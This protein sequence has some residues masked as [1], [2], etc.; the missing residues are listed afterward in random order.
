VPDTPLSPDGMYYWDGT[1]W[2]STLSHDGRSRWNGSAWIPV[3]SPAV[4]PIGYNAPA[5]TTREATSWTRPLQYAVAAWYTLA[6]ILAVSIPFWMS[7]P[8]TQ[9]INRSIQRQQELNPSATPLPADFAGT[10]GSFMTG[11][12]WV[13]AVIGVVFYA[14]LII[15][16]LSRWTWVFYVALVL[17]GFSVVSIPLNIVNAVSA[18]TMSS[19]SGFSL[20]SWTYWFGILASIP[21]A[22]LFVWMIVAQVKRGPWAMR[23]VS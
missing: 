1:N 13:A 19:L 21:A 11:A 22:A 20:P 9:A 23:R 5:R 6:A 7:G 10:M 2:V 8:M 14:V 17:L 3:A 16:A 18:S 4:W 15:G 12:L